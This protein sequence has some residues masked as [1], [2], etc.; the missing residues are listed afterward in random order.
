MGRKQRHLACFRDTQCGVPC[1]RSYTVR[2]VVKEIIKVPINRR[3]RLSFSC[4]VNGILT[5][6]RLL[7]AKPIVL[8]ITHGIAAEPN[9][10]RR[11]F[12]VWNSHGHVTMLFMTIPEAE[13]LAV[14]FFAVCCGLSLNDISWCRSV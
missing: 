9:R 13:I 10:N 14:R 5:R 8:R 11:K 7:L 3:A 12:R 6:S 4:N 1:C 2:R